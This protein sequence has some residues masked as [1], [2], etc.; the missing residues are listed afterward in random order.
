MAAETLSESSYVPSEEAGIDQN[1]DG[2]SEH[3]LP[4]KTYLKVYGA[5]LVLTWLTIQ[6]SL[7]NLGTAAIIIALSVASVKAG[8]VA[9]YFMHLKYDA[10]FHTLVFLSS[11]LFL[12]IFF[13][14]TMIDLDSRELI[15][16]QE[17]NFV[18][19]D[20]IASQPGGAP[21]ASAAAPGASGAGVLPP[22]SGSVPTPS[23]PR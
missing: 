23:A 4:V 21:A 7:L 19:R 12:A 8:F 11:L 13:A 14:L 15:V 18:L 20:E 16:E 1:A 9:G 3:V 5:L 22:P 2:A 6:V 17:G 10:R